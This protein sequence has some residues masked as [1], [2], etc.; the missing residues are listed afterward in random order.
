ML[1]SRTARASDV[2]RDPGHTG[3]DQV[4]IVHRHTRRLVR[5]DAGGLE[6]RDRTNVRRT[7]A[8]RK[9]AYTC[10]HWIASKS[11]KRCPSVQSNNYCQS[12][13]EQLYAAF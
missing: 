11:P 7:Q 13:V 9:S 2:Q 3:G 6:G 4:F 5:Y 8:Q 12:N 1:E 10:S